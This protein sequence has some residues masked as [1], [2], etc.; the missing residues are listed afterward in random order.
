MADEHPKFI[1]LIEAVRAKDYDTAEKLLRDDK[2]DPNLEVPSVYDALENHYPLKISIEQDDPKML[3]LLIKYGLRYDTKSAS[4][5]HRKWWEGQFRAM[6]YAVDCNSINVIKFLMSIGS[7]AAFYRAAEK[8]KLEIF[9]ILFAH[10]GRPR[11]IDFYVR[12][13][14]EYDFEDMFD[15]F[16]ENHDVVNKISPD[17]LSTAAEFN[18][19]D[20]LVKLLRHP[21]FENDEHMGQ[22]Y[23][24]V[25]R[26]GH[27]EPVKIMLDYKIDPSYIDNA[28]IER[29]AK[30]G[31]LEILKLLKP[32]GVNRRTLWWA[33]KN[34]HFDIFCHLYEKS[35]SQNNVNQ[36]RWE[37]P[38]FLD[39]ILKRYNLQDKEKSDSF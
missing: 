15:Y 33:Y 28:S 36:I 20:K 8:G 25:S 30:Y 32:W 34:N 26:V 22:A 4:Y 12:L 10:Y 7:A 18:K 37:Y 27:I 9:K 11:D 19:C 1:P 13:S 29:A 17:M 5:A 35:I 14:I 2:L 31:H 21:K 3:E 24:E 6:E 38:K 23:M 16:M 39:E